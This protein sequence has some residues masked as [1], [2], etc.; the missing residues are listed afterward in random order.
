MSWRASL[1]IG[2]L[3][4][5]SIIMNTISVGATTILDL[6]GDA[7]TG[8]NLSGDLTYGIKVSNG[9]LKLHCHN[10]DSQ[11]Y[12][13]EIKYDWQA[14]TGVA[15]GVDCTCEIEPGGSTPANRTAG[16]L[17]ALQGVARL[18]AGFTATGGTDVGV[19]AQFCN[20]GTLNGGSLFPTGIYG[21]VENGGTWTQ[22][23]HL[24]VAWLDS[25]LAQTI[26]A[27]NS[28]FL[29]MTN[30]GTGTPTQ[31][32]AAIRIYG[33]NAITNFLKIDTA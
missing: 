30:N 6:G 25:H 20:N 24:S 12:A 4:V 17:R 26:S 11:S 27:G 15:Y 28:Y 23:G 10:R 31:F 3:T 19:Y 5:G 32:T 7:T 1:D 14:V 22:V 21:L 29:N 18:G 2:E 16:G 13:A 33:G 9:A 8:I